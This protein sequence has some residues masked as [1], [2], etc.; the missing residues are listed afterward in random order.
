MALY[1][2]VVAAILDFETLI[3]FLWFLS[4]INELNVSQNITIVGF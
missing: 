1:F 3:S 2:D 4:Y